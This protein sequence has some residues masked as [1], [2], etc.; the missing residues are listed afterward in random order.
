M[1]NFNN[2]VIVKCFE[3]ELNSNKSYKLLQ[4]LKKNYKPKKIY[5]LLGS[6]NVLSLHKWAYWKKI[7]NY[8]KL[9]IFK[10][11]GYPINI[12]KCVALNT[13][14][15]KDWQI[16]SSNMPNISSSKL[17]KNSIL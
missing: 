8:A 3:N 17:R 1:K 15:K 4:Y 12:K 11:P 2:K 10:R 7:K 16:I 5:F 13:F 9:I 6:D 14:K